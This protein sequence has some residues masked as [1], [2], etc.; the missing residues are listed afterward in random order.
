MQKF[1]GPT[2]DSKFWRKQTPQIV[3][4]ISID[5]LGKGIRCK[6]SQVSAIADSGQHF[7]E[8]GYSTLGWSSRSRYFPTALRKSGT[9]GMATK[10]GMT[11]GA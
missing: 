6:W 11:H 4:W 9:P 10:R 8:F 5:N 7:G 3:V 2:P 1:L